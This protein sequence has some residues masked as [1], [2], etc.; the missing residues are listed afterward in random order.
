MILI[1]RMRGPRGSLIFYRVGQK[2]V[3]KTGKPVAYDLK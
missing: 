3:D 2:E 1:I